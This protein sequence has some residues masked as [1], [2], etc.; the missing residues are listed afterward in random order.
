MAREQQAA[1]FAR[2]EARL[3]ELETQLA[4]EKRLRERA[5]VERQLIQFESECIG[6][7]FERAVELDRMIPMNVE[8]RG[9]H[10]QYMRDYYGRDLG[11]AL[12]HPA[13]RGFVTTP[14]NPVMFQATGWP[15]D[16]FQERDLPIA[17]Q[18]MRTH[19]TDTWEKA[20]EYAIAQ[21]TKKA[22]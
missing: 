1:Q 17:D 7:R 22:S 21:R 10:L 18:Y 4:G 9:K 5:E 8:Q 20:R 13:H 12:T 3:V 2:Q 19:P 14:D 6:I 15:D 16:E 11:T